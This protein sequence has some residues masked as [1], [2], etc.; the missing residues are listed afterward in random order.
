MTDAAFIDRL[1][2]LAGEDAVSVRHADRVERAADRWAR[3]R[4]AAAAGE[5]PKALPDAVVRPADVRTVAAVMAACMEAEVPVVPFGGG[6]GACGGT[7]AAEGGVALD[8]GR[9]DRLLHVDDLGRVAQVE[10]GMRGV[11]LE[12]ALAERGYT[13]GHCPLAAERGT[14]GGWAA[15]RSAGWFSARYGA[16]EDMVVSLDV[17]LPD[18]TLVTVDCTSREEGTPDF[19]QFFLGSEGMLGVIVRLRLRVRETPSAR[20]FCAFRFMDMEMGLEAMRRVMQQGLAPATMRLMDPLDT[21]VSYL[22][23]GGT[24]APFEIARTLEMLRRLLRL[25]LGGLAESMLWPALRR[26]LAHPLAVRTALDRMPLASILVIGFEGDE[27]RTRDDLAEAKDLVIRATGLDLGPEPGEHWY[28][29]RFDPPTF[30]PLVFAAG[31]F[32]ENV[33]VTGLWRDLLRIHEKGRAAAGSRILVPA[34]FSNP[35]REGAVCHFRLVGLGGSPERSLDLYDWALPRV[36]G[37]AM[38][39]GATVAHGSGIGLAKRDFTPDEYRGGSRLFWALRQA[40]DPGFRM[41][42]QKLYPTTVPAFPHDDGPGEEGAGSPETVLTWDHRVASET[43]VTP[44]VPEEIPELLGIARRTGRTVT[45]QV[46]EGPIAKRR[47]R[48]SGGREMVIRMDLL[49]R[50]IDMDPVSGTVTV[51]TGLTMVHLENFLREKGFTL[52]FVP[53]RLLTLTVGDY[54]ASAEPMAGSPL[55]GT[56]RDNCIGLSAT[57]GDGTQFSARA[58]PRRSSGPDLMHCFIGA[59]G[60]YGIVTAACFRVFPWPQSREAVAYG[61]PDPVIAV[62]AIR[63]VLARD[64]SPEWVLMVLRSPSSRGGRRRVRVVVQ[65]GGSRRQVSQGLAVIRDVMEPLGMEPEP[66]RAEDRLTPP[67]K[68][69]PSVERFL[70]M[71]RVMAL[72]RRFGADDRP[73]CPEVHL[74]HFGVHG[75]TVRLLLREDVHR[76]PDDLG[77]VLRG[78]GHEG[79]LAAA[80]D[81]MKRQL[82]PDGVLGAGT[83]TTD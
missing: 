36:L 53:R 12:A 58:A 8:L 11:A 75:A 41:N 78:P 28:R 31:G 83:V 66:I 45:C 64:V 52:G 80:L 9:L 56:V 43:A 33:A 4:L 72:A 7:L 82:D 27:E 18:G 13:L 21:L 42:P 10:A 68:R 46:G 79:P 17:V 47:A 74:T 63:S 69:F 29:H 15:T 57:L 65:M 38:K 3:T 6:S 73:E 70:P 49:D 51:Q 2:A 25:D 19:R 54:L 48:E 77:A 44:E 1:R 22:G 81:V 5:V 20:R 61:T 40:L 35:Y 76:I 14:V 71:D 60:R 16:F 55:Y 24:A 59:R 23:S 30:E 26:A 34:F 67:A 37:G 32:V 62:S 39:A 50:I